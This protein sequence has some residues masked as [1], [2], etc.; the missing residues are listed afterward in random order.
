MAA[1]AT[2]VV[3]VEMTVDEAKAVV[4]QVA[5]P[6]L[7]TGYGTSTLLGS[8]AFGRVYKAEKLDT[9]QIF[10]IKK[11][12]NPSSIPYTKR[13]LEILQKVSSCEGVVKIVE[14]VD[15]VEGG[16]EVI[17]IVMEYLA[18]GDAFSWI[19]D[20]SKKRVR[21]AE[22]T[23]WH[24]IKNIATALSCCA[25][26][27]IVHCDVKPENIMSTAKA[28]FKLIDF[29]LA[30]EIKPGENHVKSGGT[31]M[32]LPP[33]VL[34]YG[35]W[36][37]QGDVW[38]LGIT[39]YNLCTLGYN[40]W[41]IDRTIPR[42]F[43][44]GALARAQS[45]GIP[46]I[47]KV[48]SDELWD[49]VTRM[50]TRNVVAT[51]G[52]YARPT[53]DGV[54]MLVSRHYQARMWASVGAAS[55]KV[56]RP[57]SSA[58]VVG[59]TQLTPAA[60][61]AGAFA[62][63]VGQILAPQNPL[64]V[65]R[66]EIL[67]PAGG[68]GGPP[69]PPFLMM[70]AAAPVAPPPIATGGMGIY[71][72]DAP[73]P[74]TPAIAAPQLPLTAAP[75][76]QKQIRDAFNHIVAH[77]RKDQKFY[78]GSV[79]TVEDA[80]TKQKFIIQTCKT[81]E[82]FKRQKAIVQELNAINPPIPQIPQLVG[83]YENL[84]I[85][86]SSFWFLAFAMYPGV[87]VYR[88]NLKKE[89][90]RMDATQA[91]MLFIELATL[92]QRF[93]TI[94]FAY[95]NISIN[96]VHFD[97][98]T[99]MVILSNFT[100]AVFTREKFDVTPSILNPPYLMAHPLKCDL[101]ALGWLCYRLIVKYSYPATKDEIMNCNFT[102]NEYN[103]E[104]V[105]KACMD[106]TLWCE[107]EK[108]LPADEVITKMEQAFKVI[109]R[110]FSRSDL[111]ELLY[112]RNLKELNDI[113]LLIMPIDA[114]T[115][116]EYLTIKSTD[117]SQSVIDLLSTGFNMTSLTMYTLTTPNTPHP[118]WIYGVF[119]SNN[120]HV[121]NVNAQVSAAVDVVVTKLPSSATFVEPLDED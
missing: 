37:P 16:V 2:A 87:Q 110:P 51:Q 47:P 59:A 113:E 28:E 108:I 27:Y 29:G 93:A 14:T 67:M 48:Y 100:N 96:D 22:D 115:E 4:A 49:L 19:V 74:P 65:P 24:F 89:K 91:S 71:V 17:D 111:I 79:F 64:A 97:S 30:K 103:F 25:K 35:E 90:Y 116:L 32:Y 13:E 1:Q 104:S 26:N 34:T 40:P 23:I 92:L 80:V 107:P 20:A 119:F 38:S 94:G 43:V 53:A 68:G 7:P 11:V 69:P 60:A 54:L 56:I 9:G 45:T 102:L 84:A 118:M 112:G 50:L 6:D 12:N 42:E 18:G 3:A 15:R 95:R 31:L 63:R 72:L 77:D 82:S 5:P 120:Q 88:Y 44:R 86:S 52:F 106:S 55:A 117:S 101:W 39:V 85:G 66:D 57:V 81:E 73:A 83:T 99:G 70:P 62:A 105:A 109:T 98:D 10:A 78:E 33:E 121:P 76:A 114:D 58:S 41:E 61:A 75:A 46:R 36:T 21:I 8:G